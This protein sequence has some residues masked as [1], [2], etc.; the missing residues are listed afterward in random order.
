MLPG[1]E[2]GVTVGSSTFSPV[3]GTDKGVEVLNVGVSSTGAGADVGVSVVW[4]ARILQDDTPMRTVMRG[5]HK[6]FLIVSS[7]FQIKW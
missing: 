4:E 7:S 5:I 3:R 2:L 6:R 1:V